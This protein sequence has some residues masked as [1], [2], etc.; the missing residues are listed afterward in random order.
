MVITAYEVRGDERADFLK[1]SEKEG[2]EL[3]MHSEP[4]N[5]DTLSFAEGSEG[6]TIL[7]I[8][9]VDADI[10]SGLKKLGVKYLSTRTIGYNHID[11]NAAKKAGIKVCNA[12]YAPNGVADYTIMLMLMVLR[13]YKPAL[14]RGQVYDFSLKGLQGREMKD[15]CVGIM[16]TGR[17]GTAVIKSLSGFGCK[18]LA[19]DLNR[20]PEAEKYAEYTDIDSIYRECD[21]ISVHMPLF[22]STYHII[23]KES[24]AKMKDG[25]IL[26]N[27]ARG[28]LMNLDDLIDCIESE[29][30]G[31]LGLDTVESE[32]K[33]IH[34]DLRTDI[35]DNRR[36][37]YLRQFPNVVMT[38]H[39]AFYTDAAVRSMVIC[40]VKGICEMKESGKTATML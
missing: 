40:G 12:N 5:K 17:I 10:I 9:N 3:H 25:V 20:N 28:E 2:V 36:I 31:G 34:L 18:I 24:I 7:G 1:I 29:K 23:N 32:E 26:I 33:L 19:Y 4:L 15:L 13:N 8:S 22:D 38:Q 6:V 39:M 21:I 14:W 30:I 37:A 35:L 11:I 16:G 27:C